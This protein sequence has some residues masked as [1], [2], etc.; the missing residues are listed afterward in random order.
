MKVHGLMASNK[1]EYVVILFDKL[2]RHG[3]GTLEL[4]QLSFKTSLG[5]VLLWLWSPQDAGRR[6][7]GSVLCFTQD[8]DKK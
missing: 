8:S 3:D 6:A 2:F 1:V 7:I 5:L 4:Y